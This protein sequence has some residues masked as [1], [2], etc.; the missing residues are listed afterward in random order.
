MRFYR[1][2]LKAFG[3]LF[4]Q[5]AHALLY[6]SGLSEP[7]VQSPPASRFWNES[8]QNLS[9]RNAIAPLKFS[10]FPMALILLPLSVRGQVPASFAQKHSSYIVGIAA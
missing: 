1:T 4:L 5:W 8:K 6:Y 9:H 2:Q 3:N 10:E 7:G